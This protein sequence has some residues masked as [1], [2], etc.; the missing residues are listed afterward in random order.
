ME[1]RSEIELRPLAAEDLDR[2]NAVIEA[3]VMTWDLPDRVKRLSLPSY[4]YGVHDLDHLT[5]L[6]A[7]DEAGRLLGIAAWE[8]A[9]PTDTPGG[10]R[11]LLLHGLYVLPASRRAGI[12]TRL[13]GAAVHAAHQ[14]G[15]D[16]LLVK[17]NPDAQ[18]FFATQGMRRLS[19]ADTGRDYPY[20][21]WTGCAER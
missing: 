4:R 19:T 9:D 15:F 6:G 3:A 21:F 1:S 7:E 18:G 17:A 8:P 16:G 12:G 13:L 2:A 20:R 10:A 11:G 5:I 14:G